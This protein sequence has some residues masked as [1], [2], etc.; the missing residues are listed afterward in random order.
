[1][2][3]F[4]AAAVLLLSATSLSAQTADRVLLNGDIETMNRVQPRAEALAIKDGKILFVGGSADAQAF[5]GDG[6]DVIDLGG[7]YVTSGMIE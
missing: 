3:L 1:M 5:V 4:R 2:T 7:K 6:T